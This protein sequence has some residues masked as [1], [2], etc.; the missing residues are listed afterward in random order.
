MIK[1]YNSSDTIGCGENS[2]ADATEA[3]VI[4]KMFYVLQWPDG[5]FV[6]LPEWQSI[7]QNT[8]GGALQR[9]VCE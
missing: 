4:E 5:P 9:N 1:F 3:D 8:A 2:A 6:S 7:D